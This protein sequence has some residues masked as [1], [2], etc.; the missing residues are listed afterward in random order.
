[1][2]LY[3]DT[4]LAPRELYNPFVLRKLNLGLQVFLQVFLRNH[5]RS[6][7]KI[8]AGEMGHEA[9]KGVAFQEELALG[10]LKIP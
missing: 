2:R 7:E 4:P 6:V 10:L 8:G 9:I 3:Y 5:D 1:M